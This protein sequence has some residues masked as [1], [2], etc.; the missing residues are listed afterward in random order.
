MKG[1]VVVGGSGGGGSSGGPPPEPDYGDWFSDVSNY[2]GTVDETGQD[3][4]EV[5]VGASG[6]N[7]NFAFGPAAVRVSPGT[8]V[9]WKWNGKGG[10][11]NVVAEDGTFDSGSAVADAGTTFEYTFDETG[12]YKYACIPHKALGMKGAIVVGSGGGGGGGEGGEPAGELVWTPGLLMFAGSVVLGMLSP[13]LFSVFLRFK[14]GSWERPREF[15]PEGAVVDEKPA[16]PV[17]EEAPEE[18]AEVEI[19]HDEYDPFGTASLIVVY[20]LILVVLWIFMYFV[21]FLGR[22]PTVIG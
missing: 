22:G 5:T 12:V 13:I 1:A 2:D 17:A 7:G 14:T 15:E 10:A 6:N 18:V 4:V 8:K 16:A 19:G 11:H 9:V 3:T 20:F 21:E